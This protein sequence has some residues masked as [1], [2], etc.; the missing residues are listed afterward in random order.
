MGRSQHGRETIHG[1]A[2]VWVD[3][4]SR[5]DHSCIYSVCSQALGRELQCQ[6][7]VAAGPRVRAA[8]A[9]AEL[10]GA[11]RPPSSWTCSGWALRE[12]CL[13]LKEVGL[14]DELW[15]KLGAGTGRQQAEGRPLDRWVE[16]VV[17]WT[18]PSPW[19]RGRC[20]RSRT[21]GSRRWTAGASTLG[22]LSGSDPQGGCGDSLTPAVTR[23]LDRVLTTQD[24]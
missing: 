19:P 15:E 2:A 1:E 14:W 23:G 9:K 21:A 8:W 7:P 6:G 20:R 13:P 18:Q 16:L 3:R 10:L 17:D 22:Q 5:A 11:A 4:G 12:V 24:R